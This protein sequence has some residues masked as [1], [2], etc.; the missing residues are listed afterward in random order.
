MGD[1]QL[2][3]DESGDFDQPRDTCVVAGV[4]VH[5]PMHPRGEADVRAA[6][7]DAYP[8]LRYPPHA[9]KLRFLSGRVVA[10]LAG[11][12]SSSSPTATGAR[13]LAR[14]ALAV[15]EAHD[16]SIADAVGRLSSEGREPGNEQLT[17]WDGLLRVHAPSFADGVQQLLEQDV[18]R[19]RQVLD[20]AGALFGADDPGEAFVVAAADTGHADAYAIEDP[21]VE[22]D[23]Y[24]ALLGVLFER[25]LALLCERVGAGARIWTS[26]A[27]RSV[28]RRDVGRFPLMPR[29][30]G[31]AAETAARFPLFDGAT[32]RPKLIAAGVPAYDAAVPAGMVLADFVAN[33]IRGALLRVGRLS[34]DRLGRM[35]RAQVAMPIAARPRFVE[36]ASPIPAIA[37]TGAPNAAIWSAFEGMPA[38]LDFGD[39]PQWARDQAMIWCDVGRTWRGSRGR[40]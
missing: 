36:Y 39:V 14:R 34:W 10:T 15:I 3:I 29:N 17:A 40:S 30:I 18:H 5:A 7:D 38:A 9:T 1:W 12:T 16:G 20:R 33:R 23:R 11:A 13:E 4:L 22:R 32:P 27:R 19:M 26:V 37:A 24:L 28:H 6:L 21:V 31:A 25:T 2:F 35:A 8:A